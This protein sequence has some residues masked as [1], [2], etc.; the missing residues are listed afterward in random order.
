MA[1]IKSAFVNAVGHVLI[2]DLTPT[3]GF[4]V[5]VGEQ[6]VE[7]FELSRHRDFFG[8]VGGIVEGHAAHE[9]TGGHVGISIVPIKRMKMVALRRIGVGVN[10]D[11]ACTADKLA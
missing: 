2:P 1:Q 3:L 4:G 9:R 10:H 11:G 5:A 8:R 7:S 6:R